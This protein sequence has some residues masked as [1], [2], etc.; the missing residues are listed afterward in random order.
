MAEMA[1]AVIGV[2]VLVVV[3]FLE[4]RLGVLT[5]L[6]VGDGDEISLVVLLCDKIESLSF[7]I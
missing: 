3:G 6:M 2:V 1:L 5:V 4:L 7:S